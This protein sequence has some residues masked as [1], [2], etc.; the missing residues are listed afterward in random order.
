MK[1]HTSLDNSGF[2][3]VVITASVVCLYK[4]KKENLS[5]SKNGRD[6]FVSKGRC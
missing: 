3:K 2:Y 4:K 1:N 6:V 5:R